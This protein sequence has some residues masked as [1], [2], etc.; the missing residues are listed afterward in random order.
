MVRRAY[1]GASE[2]T[3]ANLDPFSLIEH[4]GAGFSTCRT[5]RYALWRHWD[6]KSQGQV[7]MF[8]GLH[9]STADEKTNDRT[10]TRCTNLAKTLGYRGLVMTNLFGFVAADPNKVLGA[11]DPIGPENDK[12]LRHE[13]ARSGLIVSA[14][15]AYKDP[16][17]ALRASAVQKLLD[18]PL[19]CFGLTNG[20]Y[21]RHPLAVPAHTQPEVFFGTAPAV[22]LS[23]APLRLV[24]LLRDGSWVLVSDYESGQYP[25][26]MS[27]KRSRMETVGHLTMRQLIETGLVVCR[28]K[29]RDSR[30]YRWDLTDWGLAAQ[31]R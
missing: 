28:G 6:R 9:P 27:L 5:W 10:I 1:C 13:A 4:A 23:S 21:P 17:V 18:A 11:V 31:L 14:W 22:R 29:E 12:A 7:A 2:E 19:V 8:I 3:V 30:F 26:I 25:R 16:R 15:G 20:G 24:R